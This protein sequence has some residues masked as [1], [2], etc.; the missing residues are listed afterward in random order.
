MNQDGAGNG[1]ALTSAAEFRDALRKGTGRAAV[2]LRRDPRNVD[3]GAELLR[4]CT[5]NLVYDPQCEESRVPYLHELIRITGREDAYRAALEDHLRGAAARA[6]PVRDA[7]QVVGILGLLAARDGGVQAVL[8]DFVLT[9]D[10]KELAMAGAPELVRLQ[11]ID[12]L[13]ACARRFGPEIAEDPWLLAEMAHALEERDGTPA[14]KAALQEARRGEAALDRLMRLAEGRTKGAGEPD[15]VPG[16]ATLKAEV[17][18]GARSRFPYAWTKGASRE[19]IERAAEDLLA[20]TD[21]EKMLAYLRIFV[22]RDFPGDPTRLFPLLAGANERVARSAASALARVN[23]P[24]IRSLAH[25]LIAEGRHELGANLLRGSHGEGDLALF[26]TL[27]DRLASDEGAYHGIG[28]SALDVIEHM[29][30]RPE[31]ARAVLLHLYENGP[32]STCRGRAVDQLA[33]MDGIPD[34]LAEEGRYDAEPRIAERFRTP[35]P[36]SQ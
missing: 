32:C 1:Q 29:A 13:L 25:R 18:R 15:L 7:E 26:K 19:D 16:Y 6:D 23:H 4:A 8:R 30:E 31:E 36:R 34:W 9:T 20:E 5:E 17:D 24:A 12:A 22:R 28:F 3:L 27:L 33:A 21:E 35:M 10:D 14:A 2:L 11:G